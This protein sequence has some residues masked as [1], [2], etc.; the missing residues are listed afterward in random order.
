MRTYP[1]RTSNK[2]MSGQHAHLI[3]K[4]LTWE[5]NHAPADPTSQWKPANGKIVAVGRDGA[6]YWTQ[7]SYGCRRWI[8]D[9]YNSYRNVKVCE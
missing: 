7:D 9:K 5:E 1:Y 8:D 3:G 4:Q 2:A 6:S